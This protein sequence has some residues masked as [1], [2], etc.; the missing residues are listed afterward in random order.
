[1]WLYYF[2]ALHIIGFVAWFAGLFYLVRM[3]VY[4]TEAYDKAEPEQS[5]LKKQFNLMEWR[6]YKII[7]N[8]AMMITFT[9][10]IA[11]LVYNPAYMN[12]G[13]MHIKLTLVILLLVYHI[14]CKRMIKQL[15]KGKTSFSSFQFRLFNE[16]PTLFLFAIV[17]LAV[18]KDSMNPMKLF[19]GIIALGVLLFLIAKAYKKAKEKS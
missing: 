12:G 3:F 10:G 18:F 4:H 13:W 8:P 14:F 9:F 15:E 7:C 17:F 11:M 6:V 5:I 16:F 1:M 19:G 2:K